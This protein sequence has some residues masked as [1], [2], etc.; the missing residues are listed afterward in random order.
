MHYTYWGYQRSALS[1]CC[2]FT[3]E[4]TP[5]HTFLG[6]RSNEFAAFLYSPTD[7]WGS[8]VMV[9][10]RSLLL[11]FIPPD[12]LGCFAYSTPILKCCAAVWM[13]ST[14]HP[15][16]SPNATSSCHAAPTL[17]WVSLSIWEATLEP[18]LTICSSCLQGALPRD[19]QPSRKWKTTPGPSHLR[20]GWAHILLC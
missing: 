4:Q 13:L 6:Y 3:T 8:W 5:K 18:S 16:T 15:V 10:P 2:L 9:L 14:S 20:T 1:L 7:S 12:S 17:T 11:L 19:F